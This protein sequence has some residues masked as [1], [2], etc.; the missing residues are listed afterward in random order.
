MGPF[1]N[2]ILYSDSSVKVR[3]PEQQVTEEKVDSAPFIALQDASTY[4]S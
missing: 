2:K 3:A 4:T 1:M